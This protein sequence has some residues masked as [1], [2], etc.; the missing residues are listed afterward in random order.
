[1]SQSIQPSTFTVP[2]VI[3]YDRADVGD[4]PHNV[5]RGIVT[6]LPLFVE[7][8]Q[9]I[10]ASAPK[11]VNFIYLQLRNSRNLRTLQDDEMDILRST[12]CSAKAFQFPHCNTS[13]VGHA[14]HC[15]C[16]RHRPGHFY[17]YLN[18]NRAFWPF[19]C[20]LNFLIMAP[21]LRQ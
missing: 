7:W 2:T 9:L 5:C 10:L 20:G 4:S 21:P 6:I 16:Q 8:R 18:V 19:L 15:Y 17:I 12:R 13:R 1:M 3:R 11:R 14:W